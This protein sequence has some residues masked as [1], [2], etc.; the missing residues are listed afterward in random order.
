MF[1]EG[2]RGASARDL[3][4][5]EPGAALLALRTGATILPLAIVGTDAVL[6]RGAHRL[7]RAAVAVR[8]GLPIHPNGAP[9]E[10]VR[11][12]VDRGQV[13]AVGRRFMQVI[14]DLL[15]ETEQA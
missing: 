8:V 10:P 7:S 6:P 14:A 9:R 13:D 1:P 15:H 11:S 5:A 12:A 2:T 3:R 4:P